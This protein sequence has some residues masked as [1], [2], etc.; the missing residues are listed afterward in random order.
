MYL[1]LIT[2]NIAQNMREYGVS[3]TRILAYFM[4]CNLLWFVMIFA[5]YVID[6]IAFSSC[7]KKPHD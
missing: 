6:F 1:S 3:L 5:V 2:S 7:L 4:Q